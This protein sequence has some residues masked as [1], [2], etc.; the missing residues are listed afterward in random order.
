[1][2]QYDPCPVALWV[3]PLTGRNPED[4]LLIFHGQDEDPLPAEI[5]REWITRALRGE[6]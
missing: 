6:L 5:I 2:Q 3:R 1:M 4:Q